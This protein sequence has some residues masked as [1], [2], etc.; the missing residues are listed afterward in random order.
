MKALEDTI[1][2]AI[3]AIIFCLAVVFLLTNVSRLKKANE[4]LE[5]RQSRNDIVYQSD[6]EPAATEVTYAELLA[7]LMGDS[8][9]YDVYID[10]LEIKAYGY[11][12][13]KLG[14]YAI[15]KHDKYSREIFFNTDGSIKY[16]QYW[17]I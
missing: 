17:G 1:F 8:L 7:T 16:I 11:T 10:T 12:P 4:A 13:L 14:T 2:M 5:E 15:P 9:E 3:G 6:D